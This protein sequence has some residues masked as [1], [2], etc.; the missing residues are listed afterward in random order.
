MSMADGVAAKTE[1]D[2]N[3]LAKALR[4]MDDSVRVHNRSD[5]AA[6]VNWQGNAVAPIHRWMRYR[7]AYSPNLITKLS[8][9]DRIL[10]PFCG[11]G[12]ILIG[13]AQSGFIS[14]GIDVNPLA[15]FATKVKLTPLSRTQLSSITEFV[16][17]LA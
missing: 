16:D 11:C 9:G 15:V 4:L 10:D 17:A 6:F 1:I 13:A 7:E 5:L 2:S 8:L 12:S 3:G 14:T